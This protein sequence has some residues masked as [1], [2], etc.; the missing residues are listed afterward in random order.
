MYIVYYLGSVN[1][2]FVIYK[3]LFSKKSL[4]YL[5]QNLSFPLS[6]EFMHY[7]HIQI[8]YSHFI[9]PLDMV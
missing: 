3:I 5:Y 8:F 1:T 6:F 9:Q 2:V 7:T 4:I